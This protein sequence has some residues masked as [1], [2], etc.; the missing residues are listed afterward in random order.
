MKLHNAEI[1]TK[2]PL[3]LNGSRPFPG[4]TL[5]APS[6][7]DLTLVYNDS[8]ITRFNG[9]SS[10]S[11]F[12]MRANSIFDPDPLLLTGGISGFTE[13]G[14]LY[15]KY[16]V[17]DVH[18]EWKV[19]NLNNVGV[20][21]VFSASTVDVNGLITSNNTV[22]DLAE[23]PFS[24]AVA[25]SPTGGQDR[26]IITK[27]ISLAKLHGRPEQYLTD[28]NYSGFLGSAA[29]NPTNILFLNF[30]AFASANMTSGIDSTLRIKYRVQLYERQSPLD[31]SLALATVGRTFVPPKTGTANC[32][33]C[34]ECYC[35]CVD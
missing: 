29:S 32:V 30:G 20:N 26:A 15:R 12:R 31:R 22:A 19:C 7:T 14:G 11:F 16:L 3:N 6:R 17:T 33:K 27:T 2:R 25:L 28:D 21:L 5:F 18:I 13:W 8:T 1:N 35:K 24:S 34:G 9:A 4:T 10:F 23:L